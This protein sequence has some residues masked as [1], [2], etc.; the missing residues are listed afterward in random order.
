MGFLVSW[1]M[2]VVA[3]NFLVLAR[4]GGLVWFCVCLRLVLWGFGGFLDF[5]GVLASC[6]VGIIYG[7]L[8]CL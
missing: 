2:L 7:F 1:L 5:L 3:L 8:G 4:F 6:R